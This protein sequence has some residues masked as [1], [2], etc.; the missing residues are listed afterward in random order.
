MTAAPSRA[1]KTYDALGRL[2]QSS[3]SDFLSNGTPQPTTFVYDTLGRVVK[4]TAPDGSVSQTADHGLAVT[5]TNALGSDRYPIG[6]RITVFGWGT[7]IRTK[8]NRVR[9]CCATVTPFP[10]Q[11][12]DITL[13]FVEVLQDFRLVSQIPPLMT[14]I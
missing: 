11:A 14:P 13:V 6:L 5:E 9:V 3:R 12:I 10:N 2:S 8:T 1:A 4:V 7:W